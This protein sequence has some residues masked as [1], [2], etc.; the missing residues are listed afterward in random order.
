MKFLLIKFLLLLSYFT[1]AENKI[2]WAPVSVNDNEELGCGSTKFDNNKSKA[3]VPH[4]FQGEI[5]AID[6]L[7]TDGSTSN[8]PKNTIRI[9]TFPPDV[10]F[11]IK[12]ITDFTK[13]KDIQNYASIK[14]NFAEISKQYPDAS[15]VS[16]C[17]LFHSSGEPVGLVIAN[18]KKNSDY[19]LSNTLLND[20]N[21]SGSFRRNNSIQFSYNPVEKL[22]NGKYRKKK[23]VIKW[24]QMSSENFEAQLTPGNPSRD[25]NSDF[26]D[27][28]QI[29]SAIQSGPAIIMNGDDT[30][31]GPEPAK[32]YNMSDS[33]RKTISAIDKFG[34][35]VTID[36][37]GD[38][39][40]Y[41]IAKY[42]KENF[43]IENGLTR[44]AMRIGG[45]AYINQ[46]TNKVEWL[47]DT[48]GT[49]NTTTTQVMILTINK[50]T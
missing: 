35:P 13:K 39:G 21:Y 31:L 4:C 42:L 43:N 11:E 22:A 40:P 17:C 26:I 8:N 30:L 6:A 47:N 44:D 12:P 20:D 36:I 24:G 41:C 9:L 5:P 28:R 48:Y 10:N 32:L 16:N 1:Y 29:I 27:A 3:S 18:G 14:D 49:S 34:N 37:E 23:D 50:D 19:V 25:L 2:I 33:G 46:K 7:C 45:S 38:V 15:Y